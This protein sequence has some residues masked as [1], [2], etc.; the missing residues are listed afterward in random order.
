MLETKRSVD[1]QKFV[2]GLPATVH[3]QKL[4]LSIKN[5]HPRDECI[6]FDEI[7]HK[8]YLY[9]VE[10]QKPVEDL[11]SITTYIH[12][13]FPEFDADEGIK[14]MRGNK[15]K[16]NETHAC[17]HLSDNEI[18]ALWKKTNDDASALGT[19]MH[20]KIE[21]FYNGI[22]DPKD[23]SDK[24]FQYFLKFHE[25]V[26]VKQGW[27]PARTEWRIWCK[28]LGI[29]GTIDMIFEIPGRPGEIIIYDW[30]RSK[31][32][33]LSSPFGNGKKPINAL[34]DCNM[35]H[36]SLQ[37]HFYKYL[38]EKNYN[39]KVV[40]MYLGVFHPNNEDY[41]TYSIGVK[42]EVFLENL[43]LLILE[44]TKERA[45]LLLAAAAAATSLLHE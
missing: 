15:K 13:F 22:R 3:E 33:K 41:K 2:D 39:Y 40:G 21:L 26:V 34:S 10:T 5:A 16:W 1:F 17:Y 8:Y 38:I 31:E 19:K 14:L 7:P 20:R 37:L 29:T 32:I 44:R 24:D 27:I 30:K 28:E 23:E 35:N 42:N 25:E 36:Y 18:K 6:F 4:P 11:T 9:D 43:K 45:K 12:K